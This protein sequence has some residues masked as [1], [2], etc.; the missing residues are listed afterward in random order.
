MYVFLCV[1]ICIYIVITFVRWSR[2]PIDEPFIELLGNCDIFLDIKIC[3]YKKKK[4]KKVGQPEKM[5]NSKFG[6]SMIQAMNSITPYADGS[7]DWVQVT[8]T[9]KSFSI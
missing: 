6:S 4:E 1:S 8:E 7:W 5:E 9:F 3:L 2:A